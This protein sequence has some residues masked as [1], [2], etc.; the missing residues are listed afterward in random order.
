[1][2]VTTGVVPR[3]GDVDRNAD[4]SASASKEAGSSP[5]RGTWIEMLTEPA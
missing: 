2:A 5:A 1:M 3:K 4:G